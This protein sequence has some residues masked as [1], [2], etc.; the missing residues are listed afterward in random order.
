MMS[1]RTSRFEIIGEF[2]TAKGEFIPAEIRA[3]IIQDEFGD[4]QG[5]VIIG[6]DLRE[7]LQLR[8][9]IRER[10][11]AEEILQMRN[12][13][14]EKELGHAQRIQKALLPVSA[15]EHGRVRIGF[16]NESAAVIGGDYFSYTHFDSGDLGVFICD[17]SGHG[18]SA[19]LFLSLVKFEF[20]RICRICGDSP[21]S[22]LEE[23]NQDLIVNMQHYFLTAVYGVF[24]FPP[25]D[26][27]AEFIF[28]RGGHP[29][30]IVY[31]AATGEIEELACP[32]T[33]IGQFRGACFGETRVRLRR[34]DRVYLYTDG[35]IETR[36]HQRRFFGVEGVMPIIQDNGSASLD[37]T[38]DA[39]IDGLAAFRAGGS[40]EDD[41]VILGF[42][43]K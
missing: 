18:V 11:A 25:G 21:Q 29:A 13:A 31:R 2:V 40:V 34:G 17:V 37:A 16:R 43:I 20:D 14:I 41:I 39:V 27:A 1:S 24:S 7:K 28:A 3:S 6:S 15:P 22:F 36:D 12:A 23:L 10:T 9:E 30:P 8:K 42:E 35:V 19:A 4:P 32:G 38:L 26:G 33:L 5:V